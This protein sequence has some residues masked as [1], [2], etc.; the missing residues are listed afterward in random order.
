MT[1]RICPVLREK[2][3]GLPCETEEAGFKCSKKTEGFVV[4]VQVKKVKDIGSYKPNEKTTAVCGTY[5]EEDKALLY[6]NYVYRR[7]Q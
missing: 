1:P 4:V 7:S 2:C 5:T 6:A 3:L